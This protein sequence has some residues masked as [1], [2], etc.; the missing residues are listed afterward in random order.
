MYRII[1]YSLPIL[2]CF[3][4]TYIFAQTTI[5]EK[6]INIEKELKGL[7]CNHLDTWAIEYFNLPQANEIYLHGG[8]DYIFVIVQES[9]F[10]MAKITVTNIE[11][12]NDMKHVGKSE[13]QS[14]LQVLELRIGGNLKKK[15]QLYFRQSHHS[16]ENVR[17]IIAYK[18]TENKTNDFTK[19]FKENHVTGATLMNW[20]EAASHIISDKRYLKKEGVVDDRLVKVSIVDTETNEKRWSGAVSDIYS[21][22]NSYVSYGLVVKDNYTDIEIDYY[23]ENMKS[24]EKYKI[25]SDSPVFLDNDF[26]AYRQSDLKKFFFITNEPST[27]SEQKMHFDSYSLKSRR[28]KKALKKEIEKPGYYRLNKS[29]EQFLVLNNGYY[30]SNVKQTDEQPQLY[31]GNHEIVDIPKILT[32]SV[33]RESLVLYE[34]DWLKYNI[35]YYPI[36]GRNSNGVN[37]YIGTEK[38][39]Y[40]LNTETGELKQVDLKV[41]P[42]FH[43]VSNKKVTK[44]DRGITHISGYYDATD[45]SI[46]H[47]FSIF[48]DESKNVFFDFSNSINLEERT[49]LYPKKKRY[50]KLYRHYKHEY[51]NVLSPHYLKVNIEGYNSDGEFFLF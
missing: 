49:L 28:I 3:L 15:Y 50:F 10:P 43:G 46:G 36:F 37:F 23:I 20:K 47:K 16:K 25:E 34:A 30:I 32:T 9:S 11:D 7:G 51:S 40:D 4:S 14:G 19:N 29:Y 1:R 22:S 12:E 35:I 27:L 39:Y 5:E 33:S 45:S 41:F 8:N 26:E 2:F 17:V 13:Y 31:N 48:Y 42:V 21:V 24:G 38:G 18:S 6:A 44:L